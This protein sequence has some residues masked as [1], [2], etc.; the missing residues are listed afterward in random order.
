MSVL[1]IRHSTYPEERLDETSFL[2]RIRIVLL[3]PDF[4]W[5]TSWIPAGKLRHS[6]QNCSC[7]SRLRFPVKFFFLKIVQIFFVLFVSWLIQL[8]FWL[9]FLEQGLQNCTLRVRGSFPGKTFGVRFLFSILQPFPDLSEIFSVLWRK[10]CGRIVKSAV[11]PP[12]EQNEGNIVLK[13]CINFWQFS[14]FRVDHSGPS[15][16]IF[17]SF[18]KFEFLCPKKQFASKNNF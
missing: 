17:K 1:S 12:A 3:F 5:K 18:V 8:H 6:W 11:F 16:A 14:D 2:Q 7:P 13:K 9:T 15:V 4:E 10:L